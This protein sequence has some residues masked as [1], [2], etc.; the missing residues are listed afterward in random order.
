MGGL[1][2]QI[3]QWANLE[4]NLPVSI[5][6]SSYH[7]Q[8]S[9]FIPSLFSLLDSNPN[10][11][12]AS[13]EIEILETSALDDIKA[14]ADIIKRCESRGVRFAIDDFGTGYSSLSYLSQLPVH[15]IKIDKSFIHDMNNS[16]GHRGIIRSIVMLGKSFNLEI[17]AEGIES[18]QQGEILIKKGCYLGQGYFIAKPMSAV[19]IPSWLTSWQLPK[20]WLEFKS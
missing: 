3:G 9:N 13:L 4:I 8:D 18:I 16:D 7:L 14:V 1:P 19:E 20:E 15:I 10:I 12:P 6:I 5:N 11:D 17:V 2:T